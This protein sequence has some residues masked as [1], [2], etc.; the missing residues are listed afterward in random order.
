MAWTHSKSG[1]NGVL[2]QLPSLAAEMLW[3]S[4][5]GKLPNSDFHHKK[6]KEQRNKLITDSTHLIVY[7]G[8]SG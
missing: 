3:K 1:N 4:K 8:L 5:A 6:I 7:Q 2:G